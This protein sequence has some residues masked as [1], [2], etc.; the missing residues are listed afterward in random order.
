M[1]STGV[2]LSSGHWWL[3]WGMRS[4]ADPETIARLIRPILLRWYIYIYVIY[5]LY[6]YIYMHIYV[7]IHMWIYTV[8]NILPIL[9]PPIPW[10]RMTQ[11]LDARNCN[12]MSCITNCTTSTFW[13]YCLYEINLYIL[14]S[15]SRVRRVYQY[16]YR[17]LSEHSAYY[18]YIYMCIVYQFIS[19]KRRIHASVTLGH[20]WFRWWHSACSVPCHCLDQCWNIMIW[21]PRFMAKLT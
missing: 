19:T 9:Q 12:V 7:R 1:K 20:R 8:L 11:W 13:T 6:M 17:D 10:C 3:S 18:Y 21:T 16:C 5:I 15:Y 2:W 4:R 14:M